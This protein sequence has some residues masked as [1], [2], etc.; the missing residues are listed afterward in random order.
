MSDTEN[1]QKPTGVKT[2][3]RKIGEVLKMNIS[4]P[5]YQR[6]YKWQSEHVRQLMSDLR[7]HLGKHAY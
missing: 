2:D 3:I 7:Y 1:P 5:E 6:P 4:L